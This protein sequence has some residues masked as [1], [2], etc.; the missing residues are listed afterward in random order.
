MRCKA[1][2]SMLHCAVS[3]L[4]AQ[5]KATAF[6]NF[7]FYSQRAS[8]RFDKVFG[9]G[10]TQSATLYLSTRHPEIMVKDALVITRVNA[11]AKITHKHFYPVV[12]GFACTDDNPPVFGRIPDGIGKQVG[13]HPGNLFTVNKQ[14]AYL[15]S[16]YCTS[17]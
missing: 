6:P 5:C 14:F 17:I 15:S 7:T 16:G 2:E 3:C 8:M 10:K 11:F 4:Q 12:F 1:C 9:D 13:Q